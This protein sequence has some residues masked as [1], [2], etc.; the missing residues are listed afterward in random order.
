M[1]KEA[2]IIFAK[3]P[4]IGKVKTRLAVKMGEEKALDVYLQL[5]AVVHSY[6]SKLAV[7]KFVFWDGGIPSNNVFNEKEF[8]NKN[9]A[10]GDLG[11]KM[12]CAFEEVLAS[13]PFVC[14]IGTD[15]A[16]LDE[17]LLSAAF[18]AL[19]SRE[20]VIGPAVDGGYY[21]LGMKNLI[22]N[23]FQDI[24]WSTNS[25]FEQTL[26]KIKQKNLSHHLLPELND[27]DTYSDYLKMKDKKFIQ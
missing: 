6:T 26:Q 5:L 21:L 27:V 7:K 16:E 25:V 10:V 19:Q 20:I 15:C 14:I 17:N 11:L 9:Q 18:S 13:Y 8:I 12:K 4:M 2:L 24:P 22:P 1:E 23:L 3:N